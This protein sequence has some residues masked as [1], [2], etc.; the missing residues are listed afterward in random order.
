M[1]TYEDI[2]ISEIDDYD[3]ILEKLP[4]QCHRNP[5]QQK[6]IEELKNKV[7]LKCT[8]LWLEYP[9]Y[10]SE[11]LSSYYGF[12]VKK[13]RDIGKKC[14]RIHFFCEADDATMKYK[15]YI[16]VSPIKHYVNLSKSYL[17]PELLLTEKAFIML[18]SFKANL[19][20]QQQHIQAFPWM[21]QQK[22]F[23]MCAHIAAWSILKF[24]SNE[25]SGYRNVNIGEVIE[26]VP[27][28]VNRKLPSHGLSLYQIAEIFKRHGIT[29]VIVQKEKG[30][31]NE[32][33]RELLCY[34]E[35][36]VP[37]VASMDA[38]SHSIAIIG[39]GEVDIEKLNTMSGLVDNSL[40]VA[41]LI[42][43]DDNQLPYV[44]IP[45][46][47]QNSEAEYTAKDIDF[48]II[49]LYNRV[50]QEY[51]V[52]YQRV[53]LYL[54]TENLNINSDSVIRIF[55]ASANA[56]KSSALEDEEMNEILKD[57]VIRLEMPKLVW[58]VEL[59]EYESYKRR[60]I[61]ARMIID[62]TAADGEIT[63]WLLVHDKE[64]IRYLDNEQWC[65]I[66]EE[67]LEYNM[68]QKNLKEAE[69][70]NGQQL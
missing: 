18:S 68:Y 69:A 30:K 32:F 9:Y 46:N 15:G 48:I 26:S 64:K 16:T 37:V 33:Y 17:S 21:H 67:I 10:D 47:K 62:S 49:P 1:I 13:F 8:N 6:W 2:T 7:G 25:H 60:K 39:H 20:G 4:I 31:E 5:Y 63:P 3:K 59:S 43:S 23:S 29:P 24:M 58:C 52:L 56:L 70:W 12:Y 34:I 28:Q 65:E 14:M 66:A 38:K 54:E 53:K 27:E 57:L 22:D 51:K 50:H 44:S 61:N 40:L 19:C 42:G 55:L 45:F 41:S 35:S 36:G 11:Y